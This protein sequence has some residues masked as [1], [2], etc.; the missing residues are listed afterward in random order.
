MF[1]LQMN[2]YGSFLV[3]DSETTPGE[4]TLSVR[5][6]ERV[7]HYKIRQLQHGRFFI[8]RRIHFPT[9]QDLVAH[10]QGQADGLCVNLRA[11][12]CNLEKSQIGD[13]SGQ[14]SEKWE[15]DRTQVK[16]TRSLGEGRFTE[17]WEG[18]WNGVTRVAVKVLKPGTMAPH[19]FLQEA[20]MMK[21]LHH[22]KLI[23]LYAVCTCEEPIYIITELM[24]HGNLQKYLR[25]E[26]KKLLQPMLI[27]IAEQVAAGMAY[28]ELQRCI[29]R[30][31]AARNILVGEQ[32][33]CKVGDFSCAQVLVDDIYEADGEYKFPVK[34]TAPETALYN[35]YSIKS[36]VWSFGIVL[37]EIISYGQMPYPDMNNAEALEALVQG[38][39]MPRLLQCP[40]KLYQ[41]MLDCWRDQP[42]TRPT[43]ETL[44]WQL[45]EFYSSDEYM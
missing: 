9:I 3:H 2:G 13:L 26:G 16:L 41:M 27:D 39:R 35:R 20:A 11:P 5:D 42:D 43:F 4:F 23:P 37:Y 22:P 24:K 29:H 36:D 6:T 30:D 45:E 25:G 7:R 28:L 15:I 1:S 14:A 18:I 19:E 21:N 32:I 38:Y 33:I 12:C 34:W 31:L 44:Q 10:Y 40:E 17:V 8:T